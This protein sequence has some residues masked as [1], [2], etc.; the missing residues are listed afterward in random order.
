[1]HAKVS[2]LMATIARQWLLAGRGGASAQA[3]K[4]TASATAAESASEARPRILAPC[5]YGADGE[6]GTEFCPPIC[7]GGLNSKVWVRPRLA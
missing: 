7:A 5:G 4:D 3:L 2:L 1:M 6:T